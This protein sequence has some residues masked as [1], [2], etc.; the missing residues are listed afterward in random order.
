M[1]RK[2]FTSFSAN[3]IVDNLLCNL[4]RQAQVTSS[5]T[6]VKIVYNCALK[7]RSLLDVVATFFIKTIAHWPPLY[8]SRSFHI[9]F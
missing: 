9:M 7:Y 4:K 5:T 2:E 3:Q 1:R 6:F 8:V